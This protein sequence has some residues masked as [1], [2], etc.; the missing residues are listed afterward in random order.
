MYLVDEI[1]IYFK[2]NIIWCIF[3]RKKD[4]EGGMVMIE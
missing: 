4:E 1:F 3:R 2:N